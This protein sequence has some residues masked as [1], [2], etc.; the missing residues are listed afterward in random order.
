MANKRLQIISLFLPLILAAN[1]L[2][3]NVYT[4]EPGSVER[5][6]VLDA[7]RI[8]VERTLKQKIVFAA[9]TFNVHGNWAY[10]DGAPQTPSGNRPDYAGTAYEE[11]VES[12]AFDHNFF[13]LL[14]KTSG[15][16]RVVKY[17]IG[18]TDVCYLDWWQ[19]HRAP[20]AIF[21]HTQ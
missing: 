12:G 19:I 21:P 3:Q 20:K 1:A 4:P 13:A 10:L 16:W 14:R 2:A 11:A 15:R 18:C 5:K 6:A 17:A 8:P 9:E 7:L